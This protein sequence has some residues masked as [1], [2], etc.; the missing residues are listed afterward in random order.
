MQATEIVY[1]V[2]CFGRRGHQVRPVDAIDRIS[3]FNVQRKSQSLRQTMAINIS[4]FGFYPISTRHAMPRKATP[5]SIEDFCRNGRI[6]ERA[7]TEI[8]SHT[9]GRKPCRFHI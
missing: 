7:Q 1:F 2:L 4:T 8:P 5:V 3:S 6:N 9:Q